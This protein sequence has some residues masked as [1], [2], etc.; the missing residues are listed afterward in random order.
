MRRCV[1]RLKYRD[2]ASNVPRYEQACFVQ[3]PCSGMLNSHQPRVYV[4][5]T[6]LLERKA[7]GA[8]LLW[9]RP[10]PHSYPWFPRLRMTQDV[11]NNA[12][13]NVRCRCY[14]NETWVYIKGVTEDHFM[15][16]QGYRCQQSG[17]IGS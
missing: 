6:E 12:F 3:A 13:L 5:D 15:N 7:S 8:L 17:W 4:E 14:I 1:L 16:S 9:S 11:N 10:A 2:Y